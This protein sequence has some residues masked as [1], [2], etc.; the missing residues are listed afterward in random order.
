M[1][2]LLVVHV[3]L[4][5][6]LLLLLTVV[7]AVQTVAARAHRLRL[8]DRRSLSQPVSYERRRPLPV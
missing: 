5:A 3:A 1:T 2:A 4:T 8:L 6:T 7:I